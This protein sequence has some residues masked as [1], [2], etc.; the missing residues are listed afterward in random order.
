ML[1]RNGYLPSAPTRPTYAFNIQMLEFT[2]ELHLRS[3]PNKTA[4][5]S[6]LEAFLTNQ[7][8][9]LS[10]QDVI[11]R[12]FS[13]SLRW[14]TYLRVA[15]E[16]HV[17]KAISNALWEGLDQ[18]MG[19]SEPAESGEGAA[20]DWEDVEEEGMQ[21]LA[22]CCPLCFGTEMEPGQA[23]SVWSLMKE[24]SLLPSLSA[25]SQTS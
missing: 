9:E 24:M 18:G 15:V 4:W 14:F 10:G 17:R 11:R 2:R 22:R 21:H 5:C 12:K 8:F 7:G 20:E 6:T 23:R 19:E 1:L 13:M 16:V 3:P 25:R